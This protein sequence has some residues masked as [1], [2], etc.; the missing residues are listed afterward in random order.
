V[1]DPPTLTPDEQAAA[2]KAAFAAFGF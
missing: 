2:I 1:P